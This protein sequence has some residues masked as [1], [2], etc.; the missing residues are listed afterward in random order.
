MAG[1]V[2]NKLGDTSSQY[3]I[4]SQ[5]QKKADL[6][7]HLLKIDIGRGPGARGIGTKALDCLLP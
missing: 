5:S 2:G 4:S 6:S 7:P 1:Q 3:K